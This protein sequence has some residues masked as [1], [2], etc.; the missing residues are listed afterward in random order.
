M[1]API[2]FVAACVAAGTPGA[3]GSSGAA[4]AAASAGAA[5]LMGL[6]A[7]AAL[8]A[9]ANRRAGAPCAATGRRVTCHCIAAFA[10]FGLGCLGMSCEHAKAQSG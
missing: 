3:A 4:A 5:T 9:R 2:Y 1:T 6:L 10:A 7:V 8:A